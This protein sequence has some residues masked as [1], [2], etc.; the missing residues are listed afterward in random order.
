MRM[1][2]EFAAKWGD[3]VP[4]GRAGRAASHF[5]ADRETADAAE[6][7]TVRDA[8]D[9]R[10]SGVEPNGGDPA[11]RCPASGMASAPAADRGHAEV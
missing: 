9:G 6:S 4:R 3:S 11:R 1:P 7:G 2:S 8:E 5:P 10:S